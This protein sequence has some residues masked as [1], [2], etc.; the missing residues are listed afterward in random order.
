MSNEP[1]PAQEPAATLM[2]RVFALVRACPPGKVTT[3]GWLARTVG[4]PRGARM[5][6]WFMSECPPDVPAQRVINS[7]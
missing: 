1:T 5:V 6:G 7:I 4:Y 3:Y 2:A